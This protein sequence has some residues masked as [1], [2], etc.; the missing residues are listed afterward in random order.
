MQFRGLKRGRCVKMISA[1]TL[2][3]CSSCFATFAATR[4][5]SKFLVGR[6]MFSAFRT[7]RKPLSFL[8]RQQCCERKK[9]ELQKKKAKKKAG[10]AGIISPLA[11]MILTHL[12]GGAFGLCRGL[13]GGSNAGWLPE[14]F[15]SS[16]PLSRRGCRRVKQWRRM[17]VAAK[18]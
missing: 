10:K 15:L 6:K 17:R 1:A 18:W 14:W 11:V 2:Q 13:G 5:W 9:M 8:Q 16:L 12:G 3:N 7:R 4:K